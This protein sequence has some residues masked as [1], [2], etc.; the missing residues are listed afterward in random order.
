MKNRFHILLIALLVSGIAGAA[1]VTRNKAVSKA[2][3]FLGVEASHARLAISGRAAI[4]A[5][6]SG[7]PSYY[8]F[9]KD[10]GG[11]VII[12]GD[13]C[14]VPVLGYSET[15]HIDGDRIPANMQH[16][17]DRVA[18]AASAFRKYNVPQRS[19]ISAM[20][21]SGTPR[22]AAGV[23][24]VKLLELPTWYQEHPYNWY[25]PYISKYDEDRSMTG[26]VAT[27]I[28]MVMRYYEWPPCGT[29]TLPDYSMDFWPDANSNKTIKIAIRGHQLGHEYKWSMMPMD[30]I[31]KQSGNPT[32]A[33]K[34]VAWLLYD[35]GI[36]MQATYSYAG[37]GA[38]TEDIPEAMSQYMHYKN[39]SRVIYFNRYTKTAWILAI[40]EQIDKGCPVLYGGS[41]DG[42]GHQF[43]VCGYD[44]DDNLYVNWGWGGDCDGYFPVDN[45]AP[46]KDEDLSYLLDYG[47]TQSYINELKAEVFDEDIDALID[48][49]PDKSTTPVPVA[50][51]EPAQ[52]QV[53]DADYPADTTPKNLY[54]KAGK[55]GKYSYYGISRNDGTFGTVSKGETML[56][57]AGLIYNPGSSRY[58]GYFR[59]DQVD[60]KGNYIGTLGAPG[61]SYYIDGGKSYYIYD[62]SCTARDDVKLGDVIRLYTSTSAT[63]TYKLVEWV[64]EYDTVGEMPMIPM[65]FINEDGTKII[66]AGGL[67][68]TAKIQR[69]SN[70]DCYATVTYK[71]GS[72]EWIMKL[73]D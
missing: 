30:D 60:Y 56:L 17:L 7:D 67:I 15:G 51:D 32:E 8:I 18:K 55:T 27:A 40:E 33:E 70:G 35:L 72:T 26:C 37:T 25:C 62:V 22:R 39:T 65:P 63:G 44:A 43:I 50:M 21:S 3:D 46:Y 57:N 16:W 4:T 23:E 36:M 42:G 49:E 9:N 68:E 12:A 53:L 61:R 73:S 6:S 10:E 34:Q 52:Y 28:G 20:W 11:F 5:A 38:Y 58:T 1:P 29:G 2:A 24:P 59:F 47:Y 71:D 13:D 45:F 14:M 48:L 19:D 54:L 41:S 31:T 66:N 69:E 64:D